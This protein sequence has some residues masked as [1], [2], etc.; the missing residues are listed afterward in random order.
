MAALA[1]IFIVFN[2]NAGLWQFVIA[3]CFVLFLLF[4]FNWIT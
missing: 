4:G 3:L 2:T 1:R